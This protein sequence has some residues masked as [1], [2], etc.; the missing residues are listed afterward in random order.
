MDGIDL[1]DTPIDLRPSKVDLISKEIVIE[2][3][4]ENGDYFGAKLLESFVV[5]A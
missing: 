1:Y 5:P 3:L 2:F 4:R